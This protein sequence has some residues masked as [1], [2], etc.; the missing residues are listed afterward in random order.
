MSER[1][2]SRERSRGRAR[3]SVGRRL[4]FLGLMRRDRRGFDGFT[5]LE[6]MIALLILAMGLAA[7]GFANSVSI[8]QVARVTRMTTAAFLMEGVVNDIH[9]H[10]VRQGFPSNSIEDREC[11][12]PRDFQRDFRCRYDLKAMN[13]TP[14]VISGLV[15]AGIEQFMGGGGGNVAQPSQQGQPLPK[16]PTGQTD[17]TKGQQL[18]PAKIAM[19]APLFGPQ[20]NDIIRLCNINLG[21]IMMG[22]TSLTAYMPQIIDQVSKRTRQLTV[23]LTWKD[24]PRKQRELAVQTFIVSIPEEEKQA[25][26]EAEKARELDDLV[27]SSAPVSCN[28]PCPQGKQCVQGQC[29]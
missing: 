16:A 29:R 4:V 14:D 27:R 20:G 5:L 10:Y 9:A 26:N 15:Q 3:W 17:L 2:T 23:R 8:S 7:L 21:A 13:L 12:L 19:L 25:L 18:D 22:I 24:G 1:R 11:E 28:P 6:V